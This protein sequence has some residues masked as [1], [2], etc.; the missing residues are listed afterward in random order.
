MQR[1]WFAINMLFRAHL[2]GNLGKYDWYEEYPTKPASFVLNGFIYSLLGLYDLNATAP[3]HLTKDVQNLYNQGMVSLKK[4][5]V[6]FDTGS[7]TIYDLRH[8]TL[9]KYEYI[10]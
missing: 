4:M 5:L 9:G 2:N 1:V 8:F 3:P 7:G 6:L 10:V